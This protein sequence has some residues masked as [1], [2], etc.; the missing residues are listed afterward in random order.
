MKKLLISLV[1]WGPCCY[2]VYPQCSAIEVNSAE[3]IRTDSLTG[4]CTYIIQASI[5]LDHGNASV[6]TFYTCGSQGQEILLPDCFRWNN[7]STQIFTS[8][9]FSCPCGEVV[10]VRMVGQSNPSCGGNACGDIFSSS[11]G[12]VASGQLALDLSNFRV[13]GALPNRICFSWSM[14][15]LEAGTEFSLECSKDGIAFY[16]LSTLRAG[17]FKLQENMA[18]F[19][20]NQYG[21]DPY[22]RLKS[23]TLSG[24]VSY[25][26]VRYLRPSSLAASIRYVGTERQIRLTGDELKLEAGLLMLFNSHGQIVFHEQVRSNLITL[27]NLPPGLYVVR[28]DFSGTSLVKKIRI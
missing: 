6:K 4:S 8:S 22:F 25:S 28:I 11:G 3:V 1:L 2:L 13:Q 23:V 21:Q 12:N 16:L 27:P 10:Y 20:L 26:P 18:S 15:S 24:E 19:C 14:A 7:P 9:A 17:D 5:T